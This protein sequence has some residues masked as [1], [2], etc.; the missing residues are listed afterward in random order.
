MNRPHMNIL[1]ICSSYFDTSLYKNLFAEL[2]CHGVTNYVYV[3]RWQKDKEDRDK[4]I[5]VVSK[6]FSKLYKLLYWGEQRYI[7]HDIEQKIDLSDVDIVHIHRILYGGYVALQLKREY[8]IPY[9]VEIR[10]SDLYGF[11]RNMSI[12]KRHCWN[13]IENASKVIFKSDAY[14]KDVWSRYIGDNK[15]A[16]LDKNSEVLPNG[17]NEFFI[18]NRIE[19]G[20]H[21]LPREGKIR[22]I[23]VGN[24]DVNK[25]VTATIRAVELLFYKGY[26][27]SLRLAGKVKDKV[28]FEKVCSKQYVEYLGILNKEQIRDEL[29]A[30]DI[31]VMPS[32]HETFGLVYAEAMT[33][34]LP[35]IYTRGQGFDGQYKEGEVGFSVDCF[36]AQEIADRILDILADY[37][38]ISDRCII[39][40]KRYDW[41][42]IAQR[43]KEIYDKC[44]SQ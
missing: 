17:I 11:G 26:N 34:G 25:N 23:A 19:Q 43:Y 28:L 3:P 37:R 21:P 5:Y 18:H 39:N 42:M 22:L 40:S 29:L 35:V 32:I 1:H 12:Y 2:E 33:Q 8:N 20:S 14:K 7:L 24:I 44:T 9:I 15:H 30:A 31:F 38:N 36:N 16:L 6:K 10:N 41:S 27:V 13:I 4:H